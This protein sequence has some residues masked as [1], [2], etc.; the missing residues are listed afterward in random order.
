[1]KKKITVD[2]YLLLYCNQ[3]NLY[4]KRLLSLEPFYWLL[5]KI[6]KNKRWEYLFFKYLSFLFFLS[7]KNSGFG[8]NNR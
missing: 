8:N 6:G 1:M 7:K 3:H 4:L 5:L 2:C